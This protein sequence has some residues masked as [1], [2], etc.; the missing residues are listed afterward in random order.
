MSGH[1]CLYT[2]VSINKYIHTY[3]HKTHTHTYIYIY[4]YILCKQIYIHTCMNACIH[5]YMCMFTRIGLNHQ[6]L[7]SRLMLTY[8]H[9][10]Q[11]RRSALLSIRACWLTLAL[12]CC[13]RVAMQSGI[14]L[15]RR[16]FLLAVACNADRIT[17][18]TT[19]TTTSILRYSPLQLSRRDHEFGLWCA[20][21]H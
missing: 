12:F 1:I 13:F 14:R 17:T 8:G 10:R 7:P 2:C 9:Q 16:Y 21:C 15:T 20:G 18:T 5:A 19:T 4:I 6:A 11:S 3:I